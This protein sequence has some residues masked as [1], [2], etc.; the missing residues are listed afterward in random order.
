VAV[1]DSTVG[2]VVQLVRTL[3]CHAGR[4]FKCCRCRPSFKALAQSLAS[5]VRAETNN[6]EES[7]PSF[8]PSTHAAKRIIT[9]IFPR[10]L[11]A[12]DQSSNQC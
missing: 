7:L 1:V 5:D 3:P 9:E 11:A 12:Y 6:K 4:V 8:P 2:D 10:L